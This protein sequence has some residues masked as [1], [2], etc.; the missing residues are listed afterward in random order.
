MQIEWLVV[1]VLAA[2]RIT[3]LLALEDGPFDFVLRL[4]RALGE[5]ALG[6]PAGLLVLP[7][8]V[9][10]SGRGCRYA[11]GGSVS[12]AGDDLLLWPALSG[13]A[14]LLQRATAHADAD[15]PAND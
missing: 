13:G 12:N 7:E 8:P 11:G 5:R 9:G 6:P 15:S 1:G 4:R 14:L 10:G 2:W 3:H